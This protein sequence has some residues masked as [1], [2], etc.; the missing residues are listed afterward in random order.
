[1]HLGT[2]SGVLGSNWLWGWKYEEK[3]PFEVYDWI[4]D[5]EKKKSALFVIYD[6][7]FFCDFSFGTDVAV[8]RRA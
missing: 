8:Y 5:G 4:S 1:M 7:G 2:L 6:D 3:V